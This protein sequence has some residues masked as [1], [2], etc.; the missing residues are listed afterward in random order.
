[1][2]FQVLKTR[3]ENKNYAR[4]ELSQGGGTFSA[5]GTELTHPTGK[6]KTCVLTGEPPPRHGFG[7]PEAS[8]L[9]S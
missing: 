9:S 3:S 5:V 7:V 2:S 1:M 8:L 4:D 6:Y